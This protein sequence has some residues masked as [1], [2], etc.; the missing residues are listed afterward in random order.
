MDK[1]IKYYFV[2]FLV[3]MFGLSFGFSYDVELEND[4]ELILDEIKI[5]NIALNESQVQKLY[6]DQLKNLDL[7]VVVNGYSPSTEELNI[8][9]T[10]PFIGKFIEPIC[11]MYYSTK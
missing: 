4:Y 1:K 8:T 2:G 3:L 11:Y 7:D 6:V 5:Y 9:V 10:F